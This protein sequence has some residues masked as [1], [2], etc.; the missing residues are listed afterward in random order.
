MNNNGSRKFKHMFADKL[1]GTVSFSPIHCFADHIS[2][3]FNVLYHAF[4]SYHVRPFSALF[5][6]VQVPCIG[7][8]L[9]FTHFSIIE[10]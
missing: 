1:G 6:F 2:L 9:T 3:L 5:I 10:S 4:S 8:I 7:A